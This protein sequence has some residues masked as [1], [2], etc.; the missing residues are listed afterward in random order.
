MLPN[1]LTFMRPR[2]NPR[3]AVFCSII[4]DQPGRIADKIV[5]GLDRFAPVGVQL[6]LALAIGQSGPG[7]E[8]AL[9]HQNHFKST[10][11]N[12][13]ERLGGEWPRPKFE[14]HREVLNALAGYDVELWVWKV[15]RAARCDAA[16]ITAVQAT[17]AARKW[18]D[19]PWC[20]YWRFYMHKVPSQDRLVCGHR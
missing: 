15:L 12:M 2:N 16:V 3:A 8:L 7:G 9:L 4:I 17:S 10:F 5:F 18:R 11:F 14:S 6:L 20:R 1:S 19:Q 13:V